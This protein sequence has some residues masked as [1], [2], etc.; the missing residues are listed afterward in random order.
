[1]VKMR[2]STAIAKF[3]EKA[4]TEYFFGYVGH[5][6][7]ALLD[8]LAS[9]TKIKGIRSR[10]EDHAMH[11]ADCYFRMRRGGPIPVVCTTGGPG[12]TNIVGPLAEAF[13]EDSA[14]IVLVGA[15]PTQW[16]DR[17]GIQESYRYGPEEWVQIVK[18]IS[19]KAFMVNR[20]DTALEMF[21]RAYKTA[22]T[23][24]PGPVVVQVPFDIQNTE[25]EV[26]D[27]PDPRQWAHFHPSGPDMEGVRRA[28]DF[29]T[30]SER[31]FALVSTGLLNAG[32]YEELLEFAESFQVPVGTT[33]AGKGAFPEDHP[34]Y[35]GI[36]GRFGDE[37]GVQ[38]ARNC[39]TLVSIGNRFTDLTTA[40]WTLYDIPET[41]KLIQIDLDPEEIARVYPAEVAIV[42]DPRLALRALT[43]ELKERRFKGSGGGSWMRQINDW[44]EE[45]RAKVAHMRE[46]DSSPLHYARLYHEAGEAVREVD[47]ET[48]ILIDTGASLCFAPSFFKASSR[49]ISTNN[50]HFIRMGWSV[51]GL[52]GAKLAN[53]AHPAIAFVGD[54]S[55][56]MTG[57][58]V[59][60][61]VEYGIPAVWV[62]L[63][64]R[65]VQFERRMKNFYGKE[66][67]CDYK[68]EATGELWNPDFVKMAESLGVEGMKLEKPGD[69]RPVLKKALEAGRPVVVDAEIDIEI[70]PYNPMPF[71]YTA[72]FYDRG[73][74]KPPF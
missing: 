39:D 13:Y 50:D 23:G 18:P 6:N 15:G 4:G 29:I 51:P 27:I 71:A 54:G 2:T 31:P 60:T 22:C 65:S 62:V 37:H 52:I 63:N 17:G 56:M 30:K 8:A 61:A 16:F 43:E 26:L 66:V 7:W 10:C 45:W 47:P 38:T 20:P 9:E 58:S 36:P 68:I 1:M 73:L 49:N 67:F 59:A 25:T 14:M 53:P 74:Q 64:N 11:M 33:F 5:G 44:R 32:G 70:E 21:V 69:I 41:T 55:F 28:A 72:D 42:S 24:R 12:A 35:V 48:S 40:G 19:K 46:D 3:L 34:L 57:T